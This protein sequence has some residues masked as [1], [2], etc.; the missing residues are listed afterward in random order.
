[1]GNDS[2]LLAPLEASLDSSLADAPDLTPVPP[3]WG[4]PLTESDYEAL[5]KSWIT[6]ELAKQAMLRRVDSQQGREA[7]GQKGNRDCAGLLFPLYWPGCA[8]AHSYRLRR[9]NPEWTQGKDGTPKPDRKYLGAPSSTNRL[10]FP[11]GVTPEQLR[12]FPARVRN[13]G[14]RL[15]F[16]G[17]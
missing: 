5:A 8:Y 12:E 2:L 13:D 3:S 10:Y 9:D 4:G 16:F 11:P 7:I 17:K 14:G 6:R 1:M 15:Y